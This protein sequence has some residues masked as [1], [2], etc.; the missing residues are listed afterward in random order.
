MDLQKEVESLLKSGKTKSEIINELT[1]Q[2]YTISDI[3]IAFSMATAVHND[4]KQS[5]EKLWIML[6]VVVV[7]VAV[8]LIFLRP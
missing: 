7:V 8:A 2:G 1:F 3:K 6:A 5:K 4:K